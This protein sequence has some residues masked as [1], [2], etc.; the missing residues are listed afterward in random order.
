MGGFS[1]ELSHDTLLA[2]ILKLKAGRKAQEAALAERQ[3][4]RRRQRRLLT[5]LGLALLSLATVIAIVVNV[6]ILRNDAV[7]ARKVAEKEKT[8]AERALESV[9]KAQQAKEKTEFGIRLER[10]AQ[11]LRGGNCPDQ[12]QLLDLDTMR[13]RHAADPSLQQK[14]KTV[15]DQLTNCR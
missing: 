6:I 14:I 13:T 10:I 4:A 3:A 15:T 12:G 1:Y 9:L 5:A 8:K 2:P 7:E 11:V